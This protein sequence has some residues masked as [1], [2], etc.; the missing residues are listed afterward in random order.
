MEEGT[1]DY[2]LRGIRVELAEKLKVV[3]T[4]HHMTMK[5]YLLRL[6]EE[7]V[8]ELESK[9]LVLSLEKKKKK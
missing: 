2:L 1:K 6:L 3:S 8:K 7:H 5:D 9:G 4:L